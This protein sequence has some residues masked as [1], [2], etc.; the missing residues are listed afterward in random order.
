MEWRPVVGYENLYEV[1]DDGSV[2]SCPREVGARFGSTR[3][4]KA[5]LLVPIVYR[6][7][8]WRVRLTD[9]MGIEKVKRVH[10][11]VAEA[12]LGPRPAGMLVLHKD[13]DRSRNGVNNLYYGTSKQ[14][15]DDRSRNGNWKP[16]VSLGERHGQSKLKERDIPQIIEL[17]AAGLSFGAIGRRFG[18]AEMTIQDVVKGRTW[19]W[20]TGIG[21]A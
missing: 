2:R 15:A 17:R 9:S 21:A 6:K 20:L 19:V 16:G 4:R 5:K 10:H 18:V 1:S 14:N 11:L 3:V 8:H 12:F 7:D 13:D